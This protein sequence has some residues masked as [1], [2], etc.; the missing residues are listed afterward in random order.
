MTRSKIYTSKI[1]AW[2]VA[3]S[4]ACAAA[5]LTSL[6]TAS[7]SGSVAL[8]M[9]IVSLA[10]AV[11]GAL[12]WLV[13]GTNYRFD[14]PMLIICSGPF[15]WRIAVREIVSIEQS[16]NPLSGPAMS[17]DRLCIQYGTP[18]RMILISPRDREGFMG[19]FE[20]RRG[21]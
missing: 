20:R 18:R 8:T 2:L 14:G 11:L 5:A 16:R 19:E 17:L 12:A 1:D 15:R 21:H 7:H 13:V 6:L 9:F 10:C 4:L 3:L